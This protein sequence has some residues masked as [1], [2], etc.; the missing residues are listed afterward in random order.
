MRRERIKTSQAIKKTTS[1]KDAYS[2]SYAILI[3]MGLSGAS[4]LI[5][6]V[7]WSR[8]L[9]LIIGS[10]SFALSTMLSAF[11]TGLALGSFLGGRIANRTNKL[12]R[13][14]IF[15]EVGIALSALSVAPL[16]HNSSRIYFF[17]YKEFHFSFP[18]LTL[19]QFLFSFLFMIVPT[20]LMGTTFP[21]ALRIYAK[22]FSKIAE[23]AGSLYAFNTFGSVIGAFSAGFILVPFF[24]LNKSTLIGASFNLLASFLIL[25]SAIRQERGRVLPLWI[26]ALTLFLFSSSS[27]LSWQ[28]VPFLFSIYSGDI[29]QKWEAY[30]RE[31]KS[32]KL[33][34]SK[35]DPEGT[36]SIFKYPDGVLSLRIGSR[37]EGSSGTDMPNQ[38]LLALL[39][40]LYHPQ[41]KSFLCIGLGTGTTLNTAAQEPTY[42]KIDC[43]EINKAV[44]QG[45]RQF[46][47]PNLFQDKRVTIFYAD[48]RNW[49]YLNPQKYDIISSEPSYPSEGGVSHLFTKEFFQIVKSRMHP[50]GTFCQWLPFYLFTR[51]EVDI[52][53]KTLGSV[54]PNVYVWQVQPSMDLLF[55]ATLKNK[56]PS[57][58]KI[59]MEVAKY[60]F[61]KS[62]ADFKI[63]DLRR[64]PEDIKKLVQNKKLLT[65]QD[66]RP[67]LEFIG[68]THRFLGASLRELWDPEIPTPIIR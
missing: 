39:P 40:K 38:V 9:T 41:A 28:K 49:L 33:L 27:F 11:L 58:E 13:A 62:S 29:Y 31:K 63:I 2:V 4:A 8:E 45:V 10:S 3:A 57:E 1:K 61:S 25:P 54:F 44:G 43:L 23:D 22:S 65:N 46:Y 56:A 51:K 53:A 66:D 47:F 16:I 6:E 19:S 24:G 14:F 55:I 12:M 50:D 18:L 64:R 17:L 34:F 48:A 67:I 60:F 7:I 30:Q 5:F 42:Q 36:L 21:I 37:V 68:A 59:K 32:V 15:I 52:F 20:I 26:L 35:D